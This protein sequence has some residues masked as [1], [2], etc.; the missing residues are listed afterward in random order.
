LR[1]ER[2]ENERKGLGAVLGEH[3]DYHVDYVAELRLIRCRHVNEDVLR[4]ERDLGMI[5]VDLSSATTT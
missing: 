4:I 1:E 5:R 3:G 2:G